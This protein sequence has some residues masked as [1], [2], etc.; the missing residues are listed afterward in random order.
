MFHYTP[1][2]LTIMLTVAL[3]A[4]TFLFHDLQSMTVIDTDPVD[5]YHQPIDQRKSPSLI[6]HRVSVQHAF[7]GNG[8]KRDL[9]VELDAHLPS[10]Q[11]IKWKL[12]FN[13]P[14][15]LIVDVFRLNRLKRNNLEEEGYESDQ[16]VDIESGTW[17]ETSLP[18]KLIARFS[19]RNVTKVNVVIAEVMARYHLPDDN[20]FT[21]DAPKVEVVSAQF[22]DGDGLLVDYPKRLEQCIPISR[23]SA[24]VPILT[25][26][27]PILSC[28][29]LIN[30]VKSI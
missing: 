13:M 20:C 28:L 14:K 25:T 24:L 21:L 18:F 26:L 30:L 3:V 2:L 4:L 23:P 1:P 12:T 9:L 7:L 16:S 8:L 6:T 29:Y 19:T 15:S 17:R 10:Q 27:T 11:E 22:G 5:D